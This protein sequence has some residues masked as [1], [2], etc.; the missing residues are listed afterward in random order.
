MALEGKATHFERAGYWFGATAFVAVIGVICNQTSLAQFSKVGSRE[1][2]W[3][4]GWFRLGIAVE[5]V[6]FVCF[7]RA[8]QLGWRNWRKERAAES[9]NDVS[10]PRADVPVSS[11]EQPVSGAPVEE[12]FDSTKPRIDVKPYKFARRF[13]HNTTIRAQ[14]TINPYAGRLL[15]FKGRIK[16]VETRSGYGQRPDYLKVEFGAGLLGGL[17]L[18]DVTGEFSAEHR[19]RLMMLPK[20]RRVTVLGYLRSATEYEVTFSPCVIE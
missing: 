20:G 14:E 12:H 13:R 1:D 11:K 15:R 18:I 16:D 6:A 19:E 10:L 7:L 9:R 17:L 4:Y 2:L 3:S 8:L 5:A